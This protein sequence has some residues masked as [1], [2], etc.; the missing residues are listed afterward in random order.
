MTVS[1]NVPLLEAWTALDAS[2]YVPVMVCVPVP[3][4][5]GVYV[6]EQE[7]VN[8][9]ALPSETRVQVVEGLENAPAP[10]LEK[11]TVPAGSDFVPEPVSVTVAVQ[12]EPWLTTTLLGTQL[13]AVEVGRCPVTV[14][15][16]HSCPPPGSGVITQTVCGPG[17]ASAG[18]VKE[19]LTLPFWVIQG[20]GVVT[21]GVPSKLITAVL[22]F[23]Y[24]LPLA[25]TTVPGDPEAGVKVSV[26][27]AT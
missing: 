20:V 4:A 14:K 2:S 1:A 24:P 13:T 7:L 15:V 26:A 12:T 23:P 19:Q 16:A 18:T 11:V 21:T 17:A 3:L 22:L 8:V 5:E 6:A 9:A 25:F 10:E 27:A